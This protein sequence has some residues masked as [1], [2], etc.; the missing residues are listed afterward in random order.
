MIQSMNP[1][2]MSG[3]SADMHSPAGESAPDSDRPTVTF[4]SSILVVNSLHAS[5]SRPALYDRKASSTTWLSVVLPVSP[6]GSMRLWL[7]LCR[8]FCEGGCFFIRKGY[9]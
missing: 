3:T 8:Y 4:G 2:S 5:R 9:G 6:G 1:A 7:I